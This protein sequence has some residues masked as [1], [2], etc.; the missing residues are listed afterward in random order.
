[1]D[2]LTYCTVSAL[3][4][5]P[6]VAFADGATPL[7]LYVG[8]ARVLSESNIKRMAV[9]NG[10]VVS[11]NIIG[12][13]Q[14]LLLA[15]TP[16]QSTIHL[17]HR[18][19]SETD[20]SVTVVSADAARLVTEVRALVGD[21][22]K[23]TTRV[24]GDKVVVEGN[25]LG[26]EQTGRLAE[27][28]K[29]YP[30]IV[31][32]ASR[33]TLDRMVEIDV[34]IM[35]F[36]KT[37]LTQLGITWST[38]GVT[39]PTFGIVGDVARGSAFKSPP[40]GTGL[41]NVPGITVGPTITPFSTYLGIATSITSSIDAAVTKGD[42]TYL[43]EPKLTCKSGGSAKFL[44][45]GEVPI[46]TS[47][48]FGQT[49]VQFKPYGVKLEV[50]PVVSDSGMIHL[51]AFTELSAIDPTVT[52]AGIPGF[53]TRRTDTEVNLM[54]EQTLVISG[55][56]DGS[57]NRTIT[58]VPGLGD[59]PVLGELFKSRNFQKKKSDL[60]IFLTP[61]LVGADAESNLDAVKTGEDTRRD[62][63]KKTKLAE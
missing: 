5:L 46:P 8:E 14:L 51:K 42:A 7:T 36:R 24:V 27:I 28:V 49:S 26:N 15:E 52:V 12:A 1:M 30:Q 44:S 59:I 2:Y 63:L 57:D 25:D 16:G 35:E 61:H 43:S 23:I 13:T 17:W 29:L 62:A 54:S 40:S 6:L 33:V 34:R 9:G 3:S 22:P 41:A 55:L 10:R 31:N 56:F 37:S 19:G 45:G 58:K 4:L 53:I 48:V 38:T 11:T 60:V 50:D 20:Y 21:D 47:S 18:D 32:L 39:G